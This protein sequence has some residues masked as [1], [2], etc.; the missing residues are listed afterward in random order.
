[1]SEILGKMHRWL[2]LAAVLVF[3]STGIVMRLHHLDQLSDDSGL[4][5][6]F[7]SRH[8]YMLFSGLLNIAVGLRYLIPA[9][10]R[11]SRIGVAGSVLLML[12]PCLCAA[13]FY[14]EPLTSQH[15]GSFSRFGVYMAA[16]GMLFYSLAAWPRKQIQ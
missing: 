11:G 6:L 13:A 12:S 8:I 1:M 10:G 4:R 15:W 5:M 2:G 9:T 3:F 16:A 14:T 7:R